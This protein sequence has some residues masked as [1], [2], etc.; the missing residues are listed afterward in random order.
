MAKTLNCDTYWAKVYIAG[1]LDQIE[2]ICR[3]FVMDVSLCVT[4]TPTK[5]IYVGGEEVG[6]EIGLI[7]YPRFP[8]E[9]EKIK[10]TA[11]DLARKIMLE[12]FQGSYTVMCPD[13]TIYYSRREEF[14]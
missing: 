6:V 8:T 4:V 7:N 3:E 10:R 2:Q 11:L 14:R 9:H 12:T 13:E 5:Y 1:P